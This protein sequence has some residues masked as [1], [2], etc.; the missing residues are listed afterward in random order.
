[1]IC[2]LRTWGSWHYWGQD[3]WL[4]HWGLEDLLRLMALLRTSEAE[5]A[6]QCR[7]LWRPTD[8]Q[9]APA[10]KRNI[11]VQYC[12][13]IM[14][15]NSTRTWNISKIWCFALSAFSERKLR[16]FSKTWENLEQR[17]GLQVHFSNIS[18]P[19]DPEQILNNQ[20]CITHSQT[21]HKW[22]RSIF[23]ANFLAFRQAMVSI[24]RAKLME[25]NMSLQI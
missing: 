13:Y 11:I 3:L 10:N 16:R 7:P 5:W 14:Q 12:I 21:A 1:M 2:Y 22:V 15:H 8:H 18:L 4:E 20:M 23:A 24:I 17:Q 25:S 19:F 9:A 6:T